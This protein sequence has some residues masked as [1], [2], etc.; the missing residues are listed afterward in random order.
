MPTIEEIEKD[1]PKIFIRKTER[2][3]HGFEPPNGVSVKT[4]IPNLF[5][6]L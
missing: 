2:L 3:P 5:W 4:V 6:D 1:F